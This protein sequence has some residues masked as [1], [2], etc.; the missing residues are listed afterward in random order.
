VLRR[1]RR[2]LAAGR[3][4]V[5]LAGLLAVHHSGALMGM[6]H[7]NAMGAIVEMCL[8]V[9]TAVGCSLSLPVSR[10][11]YSSAGVRCWNRALSGSAGRPSLALARTSCGVCSVRQSTVIDR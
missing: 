3:V 9:F 2:D 4:I 1:H 10:S 8:G 11:S 5:T 7:D 6:D